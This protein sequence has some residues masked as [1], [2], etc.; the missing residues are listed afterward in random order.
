MYLSSY[1]TVGRAKSPSNSPIGNKVY[2]TVRRQEINFSR[3]QVFSKAEVLNA[4]L[5]GLKDQQVQSSVARLK[6]KAASLVVGR[7]TATIFNYQILNFKAG[8]RPAVVV[9]RP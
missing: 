1:N 5:K 3:V 9:G 4:L 7:G 8:P 2:G 6:L